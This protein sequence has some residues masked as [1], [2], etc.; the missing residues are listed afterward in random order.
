[1]VSPAIKNHESEREIRSIV[2]SSLW[3]HGLYSPWNSPGQ[4][5]GVDS[6]SLLQGIFPT[7]VSHTVGRFFISWATRAKSIKNHEGLPTAFYIKPKFINNIFTFLHNLAPHWLFI[8]SLQN[9][10]LSPHSML[11]HAPHCPT[12]KSLS[13]LCFNT[14]VTLPILFLLPRRASL[15]LFSVIKTH[16]YFS[17]LITQSIN[18]SSR[19]VWYL[20]NRH[21]L[22][23]G[24]ALCSMLDKQ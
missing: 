20:L 15:V 21:S 12:C 2:S 16:V 4:N 24:Q 3:T 5:T 7:Q 6:L 23:T 14:S 18:F 10:W 22:C 8:F 9:P 11:S 17:R 13:K 19:N 1:M